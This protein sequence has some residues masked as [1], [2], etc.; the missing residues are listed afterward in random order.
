M[1]IIIKEWR[2]CLCSGGRSE[3]TQSFLWK[4][5]FYRQ[6]QVCLHQIFVIRKRG[7]RGP[8]SKINKLFTVWKAAIS[9]WMPLLALKTKSQR[10]SSVS[11]LMKNCQIYA[12]VRTMSSLANISSK[13]LL[14][15]LENFATDSCKRR[16][17]I[18]ALLKRS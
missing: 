8:V 10:S 2:N 14:T 15:I 7:T 12:R 5:Q 16:L 1:Q 4:N 9:I 17:W 18:W 13:K 3:W 11:C 6:V